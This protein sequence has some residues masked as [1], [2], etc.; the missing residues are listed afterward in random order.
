MFKTVE[1]LRAYLANL[2]ER[3]GRPASEQRPIV[4]AS[5]PDGS[6]LNVIYSTDVSLKGPSFTI[7]KFQDEPISITQLIAW[8]TLS[9]EVAA[10][11]W[12]A[13]EN[14]MSIF[15]S[16]ETASGKTTLLNAIL[17]FIPYDWKV[18]TA[19]D[20]PELRPPH[21]TWQRLITRETGPEESRETMFDLLRAALRSRP[22]YIIVGEIRGA[23]AAVAFQAMQTGHPVMATFHASSILKMIQRLTGNPINIPVTFIDN[24]N[25]GVFQQA[26]YYRG[27]F[28][29]RTISVEEIEGYRKELGGVVTRAVFRWD[30]IDDKHIFRGL[31]NSFI[32]EKK[33][34]P[35]MGFEDPR[36]I[37]DELFFR[38]RILKKMVE[39]KILRYNDVLRIIVRF[40]RYGREGLPFA[41]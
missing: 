38:A 20:T 29:R 13:V 24:L 41:V 19:E 10:Y 11:L 23:E 12:L 3:I 31:Y 21:P 34:A 26:M 5:L 16:G 17:V 14:G 9:P 32:L 1:E 8:G 30:P 7:R 39:Q 6:R 15:V 33:I 37:Y 40:Q 25:I 35:R 18:Y 4:D 28:V 22:N 27:S 36:Q 2:T